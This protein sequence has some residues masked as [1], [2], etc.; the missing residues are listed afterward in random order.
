[1]NTKKIPLLLGVIVASVTIGIATG[2]L[3][4]D[5]LQPGDAKLFP[6]AVQVEQEGHPGPQ[7][8]RRDRQ[9]DEVHCAQGVTLLDGAGHVSGSG[10]TI[11]ASAEKKNR[12]RRAPCLRAKLAAV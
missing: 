10:E 1:M 2:W 11:S 12:R 8:R 6:A 4:S 7:R 9:G 5:R 3:L